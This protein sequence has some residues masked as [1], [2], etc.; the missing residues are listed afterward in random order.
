M[1]KHSSPD[2]FWTVSIEELRVAVFCG[3]H[4]W[5]KEKPQKICVSVTLTARADKKHSG[6]TIK[7]VMNYQTIADAI[8]KDW[9][10]RPHTPLLETWAEDLVTLCF[11][12]NRVQ[13]ASVKITKTA[14]YPEAKGVGVTLTRYR[15]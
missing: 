5:E 12:D 14:P 13:S 10:K 9:P 11:E 15:P 7:D 8:L 2:D 1:K 6:D 4:P 3:I